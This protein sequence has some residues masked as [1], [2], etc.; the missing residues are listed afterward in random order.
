MRNQDTQM[1]KKKHT[2]S[3]HKSKQHTR[4]IMCEANPLHF[5]AIVR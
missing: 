3:I 1:K 5:T 4:E 2:S